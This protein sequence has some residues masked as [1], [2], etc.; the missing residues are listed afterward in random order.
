L[1]FMTATVAFIRLIEET[2]LKDI[3]IDS[4]YL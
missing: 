3:Y 2:G 1:S 4:N